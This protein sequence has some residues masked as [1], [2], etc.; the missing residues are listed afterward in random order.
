MSCAKT[1][2]ACASRAALPM[3]SFVAARNGVWMTN[4]RE[5]GSYVAVVPTSATSDPWPI[6]VIAKLPSSSPSSAGSSHFSC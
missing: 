4:S 1:T 6:S 5:A 3:Y 2:A